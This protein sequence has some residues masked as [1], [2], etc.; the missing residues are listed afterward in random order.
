MLNK[1]RIS[2]EFKSNL[3]ANGL[4]IKLFA[5]LT[6]QS[7]NYVYVKLSRGLSLEEFYNQ[8]Y[9][10]DQITKHRKKRVLSRYYTLIK[11]I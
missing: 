10:L 6:F 1:I 5:E 7:S 4:T 8:S 2:N 9:K 11:K 3:K